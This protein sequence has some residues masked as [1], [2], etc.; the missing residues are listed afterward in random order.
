MGVLAPQP[1]KGQTHTLCMEG[2]VLTMGPPGKPVSI[3]Y[4]LK[5]LFTFVSIVCGHPRHCWVYPLPSASN[6]TGLYWGPGLSLIWPPSQKADFSTGE[7][8]ATF[9]VAPKLPSLGR[10]FSSSQWGCMATPTHLVS[11][12]FSKGGLQVACLSWGVYCQPAF[13]VW[14]Q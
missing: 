12:H 2:E 10:T 13:L 3:T 5:L 8:S 9:T 4:E 11:P 6:Y 7:C 1:W 14:G